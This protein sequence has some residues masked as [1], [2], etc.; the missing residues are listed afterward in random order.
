LR[1]GQMA[2]NGERPVHAIP[3]IRCASVSPTR[4][5]FRTRQGR[6][7]DNQLNPQTGTIRARAVLD[8]KDG[9]YTPGMF[10]RV[11][12]LGSSEYSAIL[13]DDRAVNTDQNQKY[14][15]LLGAKQPSGSI[16]ASSSAA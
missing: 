5:A 16:A 1:Y 2:R 7:V 6:L 4:T 12:L 11:Q 13:I 15:F 8:N 3:P 9:M 10:A 14:V